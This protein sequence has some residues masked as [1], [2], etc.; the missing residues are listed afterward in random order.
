MED[1]QPGSDY[2]KKGAIDSPC[3]SA[4]TQHTEEDSCK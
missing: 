3:N 2:I 4:Q 1:T